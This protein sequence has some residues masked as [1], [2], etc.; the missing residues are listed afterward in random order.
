MP[1]PSVAVKTTTGATAVEA[2][3]TPLENN[4]TRSTLEETVTESAATPAKVKD[5]EYPAEPSSKPVPTT[6]IVPR[7]ESRVKAVTMGMEAE[8]AKVH[9]AQL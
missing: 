8:V 6:E 4:A 2:I 3:G 7:P 5:A 9:V 1:E